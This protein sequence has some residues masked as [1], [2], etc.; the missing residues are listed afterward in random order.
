MRIHNVLVQTHHFV[1]YLFC[2]EDLFLSLWCFL[3]V[4]Y[5]CRIDSLNFQDEC[6]YL[7]SMPGIYVG[8]WVLRFGRVDTTHIQN[9][10][11]Q[12]GLVVLVSIPN[13][14]HYSRKFL[15]N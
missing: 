7:D 5:F 3:A 4:F 14:L 1:I 13:R 15:Q 10:S 9:P 11:P 6:R 8:R 2:L 12:P